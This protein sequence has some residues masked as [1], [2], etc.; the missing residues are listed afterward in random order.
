MLVH[1]LMTRD[2]L[3]FRPETTITEA[4]RRLLDRDV[5]AAPVVYENG[6]V[7]GIVSRRDLIGRRQPEDPRA[8]HVAMHEQPGEPPHVVRQVMTRELVTIHPAADTAHA[9]E[10][11]LTHGIASLPVMQ[12]RRLVGMLSVTDILR[13]L[14]HTD[15]EIAA[16]LRSRFFEY[17]ESH[18]LATATVED[19][20][21]TITDARDDLSERIAM[22]VAE[23]TEGVA[24]VRQES[25]R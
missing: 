25:R 22:A 9:A 2:V 21:V 14:A 6:T 8:H 7:V 15:E 1:E 18:P 16:A 23:T 19:G 13:S 12:E 3:T 10:L 4:A 5:T 17:G 11:M 20:V 24:A